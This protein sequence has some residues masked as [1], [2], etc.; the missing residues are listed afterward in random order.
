MSFTHVFNRFRQSSVRSPD[1]IFERRR[2]QEA[3]LR[4]LRSCAVC[5][6]VLPP[7]DFLCPSCWKTFGRI[8]NRDDRLKQAEYVF[9]TYSLLTW[10][11]E[12]EYFIAPLI[13]AFKQG[14]AAYA[15]ERFA[16]LFLSERLKH[17]SLKAESA[18][19]LLVAA[20]SLKFDHA[21][22]WTHVL[23][24]QTGWP[25]RSPL[26]DRAPRNQRQKERRV[27]ERGLRRFEIREDFAN[28][29]SGS[30]RIVFADDVVTSGSTAMAA[31]MALGDPDGF[32]VWTLVARPRLAA[33]RGSC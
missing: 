25:F 16:T 7:I 29:I 21:V 9:P 31:Y 17:G 24:R 28:T 22:L 20:P 4:Y 10:T 1:E 18:S 19:S 30:K 15:A 8:M 32:E 26:E 2:N 3:W 12:T 11:P 23:S 13:Y 27:G 14:R 33:K 6:G 5:Q